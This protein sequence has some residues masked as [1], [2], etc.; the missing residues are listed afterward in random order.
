MEYEEPEFIWDEYLEDTGATAA[1]P[2]SF[3]HVRTALL[4]VLHESL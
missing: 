3:R 4:I 1:A 2:T